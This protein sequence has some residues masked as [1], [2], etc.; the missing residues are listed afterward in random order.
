MPTTSEHRSGPQRMHRQTIVACLPQ[1]SG[2]NSNRRDLCFMENKNEK[3]SPNK[4]E[5][6]EM[7]KI[8]VKI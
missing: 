5:K 3:K 2:S 7:V 6:C 1:N 4:A 8:L